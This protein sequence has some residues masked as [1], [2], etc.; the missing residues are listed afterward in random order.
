M[1]ENLNETHAFQLYGPIL[2]EK[3]YSV[4]PIVP[5]GA[6]DKNGALITNAGK[7]PGAME[8]KAWKTMY[9]WNKYNKRYPTEIEMKHWCD[10][11]DAGI[12]IPL[13]PLSGV[14]AL[15]FDNDVEGFHKKIESMIPESP[16]K[17]R[18]GKGYT[19]FYRYNGKVPKGKKWHWGKG[20]NRVTVVELLSEGNQTVIPPSRHVNGGEYLWMGPPLWDFKPED[21]PELPETFI[22]DMNYLFMDEQQQLDM[23]S[24]KAPKPR[25]PHAYADNTEKEIEEALNCLDPDEPYLEWLRHG[26]AIKTELG[27]SGFHIWDNWSRRGVKYAKNPPRYTENKWR[28]FRRT[29]V[30]IRTLFEDAQKCGYVNKASYVEEA[31]TM[32]VEKGGFFDEV[33][34]GA[35]FKTDPPKVVAPVSLEETDLDFLYNPP[36]MLGV[37]TK[38]ILDTSI[39]PMPILAVSAALSLMAIV[40][41]HKVKDPLDNRTNIYTLGLAGA[42]TGKGHGMKQVAKILHAINMPKVIS[43]DFSSDAGLLDAMA[44]TYSMMLAQIDEFGRFLQNTTGNKPATFERRILDQFVKLFSAAN[45]EAY[46]GKE[47]ARSSKRKNGKS[48]DNDKRSDLV[49]P[50]LCIQAA[51]VPSN[52]FKCMTKENAKDGFLSRWIVLHDITRNKKRNKNAKIGMPVLE[53]ILVWGK[54]WWVDS[55]FNAQPEGLLD[56]YLRINPKTIQWCDETERLYDEFLEETLDIIEQLYIQN[57]NEDHPFESFWGRAAEHACKIALTI[58]E[59]DVITPEEMAWAIKLARY[60]CQTLFK[61]A[62]G[63]LSDNISEAEK[64]Q[65]LEIVLNAGADG[66]IKRDITQKTRF[67]KNGKHRNEILEDLYESDD[68]FWFKHGKAIRFVATKFEG[69]KWCR[70]PEDPQT[71]NNE[72]STDT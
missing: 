67:L 18:G 11:V 25:T 64:K 2:L 20:E 36:G 10:W 12:G 13:G 72:T 39:F 4:I 24:P 66:I 8:A 14:V 28:S 21:L 69:V 56:Y 1:L 26:M 29:D 41:A 15:D 19:A 30:T 52:I 54:K 63:N 55:P 5:P 42:A 50:C 53:S 34:S 32:K 70:P 60:S 31:V 59:G 68:L 40:K 71:E 45:M 51:S 48:D 38:Y 44:D 43:T 49:Q 9:N 17:K 47:Y 7:C 3:G 35:R 6:V 37:L 27:E 58:A 61:F 62:E 16:V 46:H 23:F 65:V 22:E 57:G 33:I